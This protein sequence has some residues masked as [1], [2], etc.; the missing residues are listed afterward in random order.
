MKS[1]GFNPETGLAM[2]IVKKHF[3]NRGN[4]NNVFRKYIP[5]LDQKPTEAQKESAEE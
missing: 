2:A 4:Y 3:G 1:G 5:E